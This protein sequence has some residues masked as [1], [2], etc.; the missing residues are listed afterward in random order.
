MV[1]TDGI[2]GDILLHDQ[3]IGIHRE[4]FCQRYSRR[5]FQPAKQLLTHSGNAVRGIHQARA[6]GVLPNRLQKQ[7]NC[8]FYFLLVDQNDTLLFK[9]YRVRNAETPRRSRAREFITD[10]DFPAGKGSNFRADLPAPAE[11]FARP[12]IVAT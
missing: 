12:S 9:S 10:S 8:F 3:I 6:G 5:L 11:P 7:H 2:E 4:T 1:L